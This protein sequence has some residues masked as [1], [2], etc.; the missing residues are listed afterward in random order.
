MPL[1]VRELSAE[2]FTLWDGL[3]A[4]SPQR[5]IF[6]Q[7]WWMEIVTRGGVQLLGCFD[8]DRLV[9]GLPL[10]PCATFGVRRL[11]QPPL[12][13]YWGPILRPIPGKYATRVSTE[14]EILRAFAAALTP[15]QDSMLAFHPSLDN[16]LPFHWSGYQQ[17]TRYT[18]RI[19]A[20]AENLPVGKGLHRS[21]RNA[22]NRAANNQLTIKEMVDP[23]VIA[24]M[25][26]LSMA[27]QE[28]QSSLEI[29]AFWSELSQAA[30]QRNCLLNAVAMDPQGEVH[31]GYAIVWDD[32]YA[33]DLYG[34]G[35]P[36]YRDSGG[37][38]LALQ[39]LLEAA[40]QVA[41][42]FDFEGSMTESIGR[43]FRQFGGELT[44]FLA[45]SRAASRRI[46]TARS[47]QSWWQ[48]RLHHEGKSNCAPLP[49]KEAQAQTPTAT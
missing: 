35:D 21:V 11:R 25:S 1:T 9:A 17:T 47:L 7:R 28:L 19:E 13:P 12:T 40:A 10:W 29:R 15:W 4:T 39:H 22:L 24:E 34:G 31:A 37:G 41:P 26:R 2:D 8:T 18:Y 6:A 27:R 43:F 49:A 23:M 48:N 33:Y 45:V 14:M 30:T 3:L 42:G 16:W 36:R 38:T 44:S 20:L 46:N 5:C 32:R